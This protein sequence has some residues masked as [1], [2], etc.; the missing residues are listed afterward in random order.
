MAYGKS[1][2]P[3]PPRIAALLSTAGRALKMNANAP[4]IGAGPNVNLPI[5]CHVLQQPVNSRMD[6]AIKKKI[7]AFAKLK[8]S[9]VQIAN[10]LAIAHMMQQRIMHR[11]V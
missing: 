3:L 10:L 5:P 8:T 6:V 4:Q 2:P 11:G 7:N 9:L 1:A